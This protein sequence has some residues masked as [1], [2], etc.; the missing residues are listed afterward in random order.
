MKLTKFAPGLFLVLAAF[1]MSPSFALAVDTPAC[2]HAARN[3]LE[4]CT[5]ICKD[6]FL[7]AKDGCRNVNHECADACRDGR[8]ACVNPILSDLE[9]CKG[10]CNA[11]LV[12][13][14][15]ECRD[16]YA[17]DPTGL[18]SCIDGAQVKGFICRDSCRGKVAEELKACR[19]AFRKCIKACPPVP[20]K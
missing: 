16:T 7:V 1:M 20:V 6:A 5:I 8:E 3:D 14:K 10:I 4:E 9:A 19:T 12:A 11:T 17:G 13:D 15:K 18:D 2:V